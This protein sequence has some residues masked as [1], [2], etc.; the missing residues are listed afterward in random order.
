MNDVS[1]AARE[2]LPSLRGCVS[3][4]MAVAAALAFCVFVE[5][6]AVA[7]NAA[8]DVSGAWQITRYSP[9]LP[10]VGGEAL[11]L[12]AEGSAAYDKNKAGLRDGSIYDEA[13][14]I[15]V[16]DGV[17]RILGN[18][19]PFTITQMPRVTALIYELNHVVRLVRM[20]QP[21]LSAEQL[22]L[23]PYYSGHAV[24][25]WEGDTLVLESAGFNEKTFLDGTGAPHSNQM[26]T[27]ERYRKINSGQLEA[28]VTVTDPK[29]YTKPF[30]A[31]FV[32]DPRPGLE[33]EEYVC[34]EPHR[35]I[36]QIPG[37]AEA[38]RNAQPFKQ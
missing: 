25:H 28:V 24:G 29:Y 2:G 34:G 26:T 22:R 4:G 18:P 19:Y 30:T 9:Q 37:V 5:S 1:P 8:R 6:P 20:D 23:A 17:P 35:D 13:R 12:N 11:P 16:P 14:R 33:L 10:L 7:Q 27:V 36:N 21:Q 15:C 38:R 32:Y 3:F 31:R